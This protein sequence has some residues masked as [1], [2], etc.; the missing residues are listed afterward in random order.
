MNYI[1][2][3]TS[4]L[5][6]SFLLQGS[7]KKTSLQKREEIEKELDSNLASIAV[8][9]RFHLMSNL[10]SFP[11]PTLWNFSKNVSDDENRALDQYDTKLKTLEENRVKN[12]RAKGNPYFTVRK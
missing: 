1:L 8:C 6:S 11:T 10:Q 7:E 4:L 9:H 5:L 2:L 3:C 12:I